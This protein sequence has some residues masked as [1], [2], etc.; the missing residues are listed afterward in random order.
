[1]QCKCKT[2][3]RNAVES[4]LA[5]YFCAKAA[6]C[7]FSAKAELSR[8]VSMWQGCCNA[9]ALTCQERPKFLAI[10]P[11][12]PMQATKATVSRLLPSTD[13]WQLR[14]AGLLAPLLCYG[15]T[16]TLGTKHLMISTDCWSC[17][18]PNSLHQSGTTE[19]INSLLGYLNGE[20]SSICRKCACKLLRTLFTQSPQHK[21]CGI[22]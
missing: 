20:Q 3:A 18:L 6:S 17:F 21:C 1:M 13:I 12:I 2:G 5:C 4:T 11:N 10:G 19:G 16:I 7:Y 14:A 9:R 22:R 15:F 8:S